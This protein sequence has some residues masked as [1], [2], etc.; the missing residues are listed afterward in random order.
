MANHSIPDGYRMIFGDEPIQEG[1]RWL[2]SSLDL[3][4]SKRWGR[5]YNYWIAYGV[6]D[7]GGRPIIRKVQSHSWVS[8]HPTDIVKPWDIVHRD[9]WPSPSELDDC[10]MH[11][12]MDSDVVFNGYVTC[13][14]KGYGCMGLTVETM[15]NKTAGKSVWRKI[16]G[17]PEPR[18]LPGNP[19]F[20]EPL[21]LP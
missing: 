13:Q 1:D 10:D 8:L 11:R 2:N 6:F 18:R 9:N 7:E 12:N 14:E 21:P 5:S 20:A 3:V 19:Y 17:P 16:V 4:G 15:L